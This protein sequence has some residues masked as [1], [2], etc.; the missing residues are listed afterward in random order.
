[1][2]GSVLLI[3]LD[4]TNRIRLVSPIAIVLPRKRAV[5]VAPYFPEPLL[6]LIRERDLLYPLGSFPTIAFWDNHADR[7]SMFLREGLA[8]PFVR[9]KHVIIVTGSKRQIGGIVVE[10]FEEDELCR[11][12]WLHDGQD[13]LETDPFPLVVESAPARHTMEV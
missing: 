2:Y 5:R 6:I 12:Q 13:V 9:Q 11:R 8:V 10:R 1:S 7:A 3:W 4:L